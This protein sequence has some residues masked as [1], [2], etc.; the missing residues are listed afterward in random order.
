MVNVLHT[1]I[2]AL[3][4]YSLWKQRYDQKPLFYG[5]VDCH[6]K[7]KSSTIHIEYPSETLS[8]EKQL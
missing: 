8:R 2:I 5:Q 7:K 6:E 3:I 4:A 1:N